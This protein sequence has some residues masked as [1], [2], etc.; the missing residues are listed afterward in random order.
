MEN[1]QKMGL[2]CGLQGWSE[3]GDVF[4]EALAWVSILL[5]VYGGGARLDVT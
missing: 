1:I 5:P 2:S 4:L 3:G